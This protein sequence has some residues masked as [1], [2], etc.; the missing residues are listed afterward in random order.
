VG[1]A[2]GASPPPQPASNMLV[3]ANIA[4]CFSMVILF[5]M[6]FM[7]IYLA[8]SLFQWRCELQIEYFGRH[9]VRYVDRCR[10]LWG[11]LI[12]PFI[13]AAIFTYF[14]DTARLTSG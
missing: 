9:A 10:L 4:V 14:T 7:I 13:D 5:S 6:V 2:A 3:A 1:A 8:P 12:Y 11:S